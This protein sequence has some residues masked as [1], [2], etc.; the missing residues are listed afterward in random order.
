V[1]SPRAAAAVGG[2]TAPIGT[3]VGAIAVGNDGATFQVRESTPCGPPSSTDG[4]YARL[5]GP[6]D[7][8]SPNSAR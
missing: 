6:Y 7:T 1:V 3:Y 2:S 4:D 5:P 8:R